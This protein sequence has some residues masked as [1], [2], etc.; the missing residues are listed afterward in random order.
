MKK[1]YHPFLTY[2]EHIL[3]IK[4]DIASYK[5]DIKDYF[6]GNTKRFTR[7]E[8][9]HILKNLRNDIALLKRIET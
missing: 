2:D 7:A 1:S 8:I 4:G 5:E 3:A 9:R 6:N